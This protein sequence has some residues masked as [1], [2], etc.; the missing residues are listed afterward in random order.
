MPKYLVSLLLM[1][2]FSACQ[3]AADEAQPAP[4]PSAGTYFSVVQFAKDQFDTYLGQP[5]TLQ[6]FTVL[7]NKTD[8]TMISAQLVDWA[9]IVKLF[10]KA[11]ISDPRYLGQYNFSIL[12][13]DATDSRIFYYEAANPD[14]FTRSLQIVTDPVNNKIKS[15]YVET[16][17]EG[18]FGSKQQKLY[19][20]PVKVLQI[21]ER[22]TAAI[23][24]DKD[25]RIEYRFLY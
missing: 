23:G 6:K 13:D 1:L 11:D 15:I 14:L 12:N 16:A 25:L 19:Y 7:N 10:A 9:S 18:R 8:S 21:Q 17:E 20:A 5:F 2:T 24:P 22:E 4:D 3:N